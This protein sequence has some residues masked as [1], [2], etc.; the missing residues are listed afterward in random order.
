MASFLDYGQCY[1]WCS[2]QHFW[3]NYQGV[4]V[5]ALS[6]VMLLAYFIFKT[7]YSHSESL[8]QKVP[9]VT[10]EWICDKLVLLAFLL[11]AGWFIYFLFFFMPEQLQTMPDINESVQQSMNL[12]GDAFRRF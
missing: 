3:H 8:R 5:L 1:A 2:H 6:A 4:Y 10:A 7:A 11:L 9:D 12:I